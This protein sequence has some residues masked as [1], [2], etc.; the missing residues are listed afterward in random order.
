MVNSGPVVHKFPDFQWEVGHSLELQDGT[1]LVSDVYRPV[2]EGCFPV[3][4]MRQPYGRDI[5]STVV[6]AHPTYFVRKGFIVVIQDVRGRGDSSGNFEAF[7]SERKDGAET[8]RWAANLPGSNGRVGMYGFSYQGYTQWAA[9]LEVCPE[10]VAIAPHMAAADLY[11]GW[12]YRSG[13]LQLSTTLSWGN[14]MLREDARR[15]HHPAYESLEKTWRQSGQFS[16]NFPLRTPSPLVDEGLPRYVSNWLKN[17]EPG[18]YW[19]EL[20]IPTNATGTDLPQ[21]HIAGWFDFYLRGSIEAYEKFS[22]EAEKHGKDQLL[23][24]GPWVHIPWGTKAG[25]WDQGPNAYYDTDALMAEFFI[26]WLK[27]EGE[28]AP[29]GCHYF[30]LGDKSWRYCS[31][32]PP[33]SRKRSLHL[34]SN[35]NANSRFGDGILSTVPAGHV[36][37]TDIFNYDPEVPVTAP[38]GNLGGSTRFGSFNLAGQQEG[39]N[40]LVYTSEPAGSSVH[41]AGKPEL[42]LFLRSSAPSSDIVARLSLVNERQEAWF[43]TLGAQPVQFPDSNTIVKIRLEL[44]PIAFSLAPGES[45]RLDIASSAFPLLAKSPNTEENRLDL[46]SAASFRRALHFIYHD[47]DHPSLLSLPEI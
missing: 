42:T 19:E 41:Y 24:I 45:L 43:L 30:S 22:K 10:L 16:F 4:L 32:W 3:L 27:G 40:L 28:K 38:G 44:D 25:D 1:T 2:S 7:H 12:F 46:S 5:A 18:A 34:S 6:Y 37:P 8:V 35:G 47:A 29:R 17:D 21:F 33:D 26:S 39:N 20:N 36:S 23:V 15:N 9:A 11:N 14:Q 31:Q 13:I